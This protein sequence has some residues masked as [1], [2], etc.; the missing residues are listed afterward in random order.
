MRACKTYLYLLCLYSLPWL[1]QAQQYG[2]L[3]VY[4]QDTAGNP[5]PRVAVKVRG[6]LSRY[7]TNEQGYAELKRMPVGTLRVRLSHPAYRQQE[8]DVKVW[9]DSTTVLRVLL[10]Q[11]ALEAIKVSPSRDLPSIDQ[12][13]EKQ[14]GI[15]QDNERNVTTAKGGDEGMIA[16][17]AGGITASE[18]SSQYR[19]RGGNYDENLIYINGI[20]LYRPQIVRSGQV[21]GLGVVNTK[22]VDHVSFSTG[23]FQ[24]QYADRLSSV[25]NI[26]Y[27]EP[28][29]FRAT[30]ELGLIT[31]S[32]SAQGRNQVRKKDGSKQPGGFTYLFGARGFTLRYLLGSLNTTG[33]YRPVFADGQ[34]LFSYVP[35]KHRSYR[36]RV[37]TRHDD[38]TDSVLVP[39]NNLKISL[40]T[41]V[42]RNNYEFF[43]ENR[44]TTFG[45]LQTPIRLFVAFVGKEQ[46]TYLT[47]QS[48][49]ILEHKPS[50]RL[51]LR[52]ALTG[53]RSEEA[54]IIDVEGAYRLGDVSSNLGGDDFDEVV[55][56]RGI[57]SELRYARNY[58]TVSI[59]RAEHDGS[60]VLDRDL[61]KKTANSYTRHRLLWGARYEVETIDDQLT[62]WAALDSADFLDITERVQSENRLYSY[63]SMGYLQHNWRLGRATM[64]VSGVRSHYWSL[65]DQALVSPRFQLVYDA[66]QLRP[67]TDASLNIA[68]QDSLLRHYLKRRRYQLRAA[69]G[70]YYQPAF[71]RELRNFD[72]S[73][74]RI[75][76]A[77]SSY[78]LILGGDYIFQAWGRDFKLFLEGYYKYMPLLYPFEF[79]NVRIRYYPNHQAQGYAYGADLRLNGEFIKDIESWV[80]IGYLQTR[81]RVEGIN[82]GFVRRPT[83][84]RLLVSFFF[85]DEFPLLPSLK[86]HLNLIYGSGLPF[87]PPEGLRNRTVFQA[88]F[89]N[90][91]DLG[92]SN[93]FKFHG[94]KTLSLKSLWLGLDVYNLFGRPN[95]VS[96][97]WLEDTF[98]TRFAI[99]NFQ[100]QRLLN[101]RAIAYF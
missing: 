14:V 57:G 46:S 56:N 84:Q 62:E 45:T 2:T 79:D 76:P 42:Q 83:D 43:P 74:N 25:M 6:S 93:E 92:F 13:F 90:R 94:H 100:S 17:S 53:I 9:E 7:E 1:A 52:Y 19:V 34:A 27:V 11:L 101:L 66:S 38:S 64:L 33:T 59:L 47:G 39:A 16:Q 10:E 4:T 30:A 69:L 77:Q 71:Y 73:L 86:M 44:E 15:N 22:L 18:F 58:L 49:L 85:Q 12:A 72:G 98:N 31:A 37:R 82:Q 70:S 78:Q 32:L 40:L 95:T 21:E 63:R 96:Y 35:A 54:E 60:L 89:Y 41:I 97:L 51:S 65:N 23:G 55:F 61:Y 8:V 67:D 80:N 81:E 68:Q 26:R 36:Y 28:D 20:Q 99:P 50:A 29:S 24:A 5:V 75:R 3:R 88:P 48:A 91:V 87:G